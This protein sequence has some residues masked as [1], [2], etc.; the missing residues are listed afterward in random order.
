MTQAA[1]LAK[2]NL[3][4]QWGCWTTQ[5]EDT[6]LQNAS[7]WPTFSAALLVNSLYREDS[8]QIEVL[9]QLFNA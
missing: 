6:A 1:A 8:G 4:V 7:T 9:H 5:A 2:V 3:S